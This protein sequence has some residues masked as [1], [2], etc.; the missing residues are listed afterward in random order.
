MSKEHF[1]NPKS[2]KFLRHGKNGCYLELINTVSEVEIFRDYLS[3]EGLPM[4]ASEEHAEAA[5]KA[6]EELEL[7]LTYLAADLADYDAQ[8]AAG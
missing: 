5:R 4:L 8:K 7:L 2:Q 3:K 1:F 6:K